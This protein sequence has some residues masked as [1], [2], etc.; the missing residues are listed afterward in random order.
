[1]ITEALLGMFY[2]LLHGLIALVPDV[3]F[4]L[5]DAGGWAADIAPYVAML[6]R[7]VPFAEPMSAIIKLLVVAFPGLLA[8]RVAL[9]LYKRV[10]G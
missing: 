10:R 9:F 6:D 8:Y 2:G 3:P 7:L 4:P 5:A 1:M